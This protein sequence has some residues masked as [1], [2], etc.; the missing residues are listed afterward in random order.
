MYATGEA[1]SATAEYSARMESIGLIQVYLQFRH[2]C[3]GHSTMPIILAIRL[4]PADKV[5]EMHH[6]RDNTCFL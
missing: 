1:A 3:G 4:Y 6:V 2:T 5:M